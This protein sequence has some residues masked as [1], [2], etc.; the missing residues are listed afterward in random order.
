M[1]FE[2]LVEGRLIKRYKRFLADVELADGAIV[3]AHCTNTGSMDSCL[4]NGA[5]VLLS[6]SP[7]PNRK[8]RFTWEMIYINNNWVGVNT[9]NS[10]K[11]A[12]ELVEK[13]IIRGLENLIDLKRELKYF[14]SR[15][16]L[17]G[18]DG[19]KEVWMEV[20]NVS[21]KRDDWALFPDAVTERG[22]KHLKTLM[23]IVESGQ[24]AAMIYII[25]RTDISKFR[26]AHEVDAKYAQLLEEAKRVGV[27]VYPVQV[28]LN[29][30]GIE[31]YRSL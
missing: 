26:A 19:T 16:D 14:D 15:F 28:Q 25:Q 17:F 11:I 12:H 3:T 27:E 31:F 13:N 1:K 18:F 24:R 30:Q 5:G 7:D 2:K 6:P 29:E 4:E 23:K 10:N 20:K 8:T 22:Q 21:M 9:Q